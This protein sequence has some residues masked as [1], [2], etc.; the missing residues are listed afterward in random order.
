[1]IDSM[2]GFWSR[3]FNKV[4]SAATPASA[5]TADDPEP[6]RGVQGYNDNLVEVRRG[7]RWEEVLEVSG[8]SQFRRSFQRIFTTLGRPEGGVTFQDA[9][10]TITRGGPV[11]VQIMGEVVGYLSED[12]DYYVGTVKRSLAR[13]GRGEVAVI[14]AR[15]WARLDQA[16]LWRARVS[17]AHNIGK[18]E[19]EEDFREDRLAAERWEAEKA[20][21]AAAQEAARAEKAA[22]REAK[23]KLEADATAAGTFDGAHVSQ[24]Q[25]T[26][27]ALKA[28]GKI[29]ELEALLAK[30]VDAAEAESA[31]RGV[32]PPQ[33]PALQLSIIYRERE[34]YASEV[35]VL[36][37]FAT[38]CG[39]QP[40]PT[41]MANNLAKARVKAAQ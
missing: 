28:E 38:A 3:L 16:G 37:R 10:L 18:G 1:M 35:A 15:I 39:D 33:W 41:R 8:E 14:H 27:T 7:E 11:A 5:S 31:V 6:R 29:D 21:K 25:A 24:H 19:R 9:R 22:V 13:L 32:V 20:E 4:S 34:D 40:I 36:E 23:Q 26:A 30:C 2:A 12:E 17:L